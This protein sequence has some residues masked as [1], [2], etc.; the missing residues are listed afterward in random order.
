[1][2]KSS[3]L[4]FLCMLSTLSASADIIVETSTGNKETSTISSVRCITLT[5]GNLQIFHSNGTSNST[6]LNQVSKIYFGTLSGISSSTQSTT[7]VSVAGNEITISPIKKGSIV[8][9]VSS[10]GTLVYSN[11]ASLSTVKLD[12][13]NQ[14]KGVYIISIDGQNIKIK[15]Q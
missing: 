4:L 7:S 1:M 14:P 12:I 5:G 13:S 3:A 2:R 10:D 15:K 9:M 11:K 8:K 6:P